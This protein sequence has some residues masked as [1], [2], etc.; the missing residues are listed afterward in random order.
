M[1]IQLNPPSTIPRSYPVLVKW[2]DGTLSE[3]KLNRYGPVDGLLEKMVG[4]A[5]VP[6]VL[7]PAAPIDPFDKFLDSI[8]RKVWDEAMLQSRNLSEKH[9]FKDWWETLPVYTPAP[10]GTVRMY[11]GAPI[12]KEMAELIW[13]MG[14]SSVTP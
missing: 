7:P 10:T 3:I 4:W 2:K 13:N 14:K 12:G 9:T 6:E 11:L 8:P 5:E 1:K